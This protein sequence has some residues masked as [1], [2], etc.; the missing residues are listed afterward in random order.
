MDSQVLRLNSKPK[1]EK[2]NENAEDTE[3]TWVPASRVRGFQVGFQG[4]LLQQD[5]A[6][7]LQEAKHAQRQRAKAVITFRK[8]TRHH[9]KINKQTKQRKPKG[10]QTKLETKNTIVCV[11]VGCWVSWSITVHLIPE[12]VLQASVSL[13]ASSPTILPSILE[14]WPTCSQDCSWVLGT[15]IQALM[16]NQR[17]STQQVTSSSNYSLH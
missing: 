5:A 16:L 11:C 2:T 12:T 10:K 9:E 1:A 6:R 4:L 15:Q 3:A 14:L 7:N 17:N 8:S 13:A